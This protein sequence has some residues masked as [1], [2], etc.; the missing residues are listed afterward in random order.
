MISPSARIAT[1]NTDDRTLVDEHVT[2]G[3]RRIE[4]SS[5]VAAQVDNEA[6]DA[7]KPDISKEKSVAQA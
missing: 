7:F 4:Q 1:T 5:A 2:D 3:D 6:I